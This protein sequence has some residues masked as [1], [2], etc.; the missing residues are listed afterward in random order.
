[1]NVIKKNAL[2]DPNRFCIDDVLDYVKE[3]KKKLKKKKGKN[4]IK[5]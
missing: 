3:K 1:M 4:A 2:N 5:K